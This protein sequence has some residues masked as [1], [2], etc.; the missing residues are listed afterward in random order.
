MLTQIREMAFRGCTSLA[1]TELPD[2][3]EEILASSFENCTNLNLKKLPS[4]VRLVGDSAFVGCNSMRK[5]SEIMED[6]NRRFPRSLKDHATLM[7]EA[8]RGEQNH[9]ESESGCICF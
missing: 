1:L 7:R 9:E 5:N 8:R 2:G 3:L 4:S 6:L